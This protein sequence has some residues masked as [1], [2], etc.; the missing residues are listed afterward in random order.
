MVPLWVA[1]LADQFW[2]AAGMREP[3]PRALRRP[4]A[5][6]LQM[7]VVSLPRLRLRNVLDWLQRHDIAC[8]CPEADRNLHACLVAR[9]DWGYVFLDG[10]D[11]EDEQRFSLAHELAHFLRD[12]AAPRRQAVQRLG[13]QVLEVFDGLRLARPEERLLGL[14]REARIGVHT[15]FLT[16]DSAGRPSASEEN[17]ERDADRLAY[18]LLAPVSALSADVGDLAEHLHNV[19]GLPA[20][21][22]AAYAA[23]LQPVPPVDPLL[24]RLRRE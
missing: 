13:P 10:A 8:P 17:A 22:A 7:V 18:E 23:L 2:E 3:F 9:K 4:I 21:H 15:H 19:F 5:R 1:E 14:L 12:Y 11:S 24:A 20:K 6:A 16:R